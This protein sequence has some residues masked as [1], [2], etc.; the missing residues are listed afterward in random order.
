M[1]EEAMKTLG[2]LGVLDPFEHK[3]IQKN[4]FEKSMKERVK[5][6]DEPEAKST[7]GSPKS[8]RGPGAS[9]STH[10]SIPSL[11][12]GPAA[13]STARPL[14]TYVTGVKHFAMATVDDEMRTPRS[15]FS[16]YRLLDPYIPAR[17]YAQSISIDAIS[18]CSRPL[19]RLRREM[20]VIHLCTMHKITKRACHTSYVC[21][22]GSHE[23][24]ALDRSSS[25]G[26]D[27]T[28][29]RHELQ[30][31]AYKCR[32]HYVGYSGTK[33]AGL[34]VSQRTLPSR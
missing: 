33:L 2:A 9:T 16:V 6:V 13:S 26:A 20:I 15:K 14:N 34:R 18:C 8:P 25:E 11:S 31:A 32:R 5:N 30:R 21:V 23:L 19:A 29:E 4:A 27:G 7:P 1:R 22:A 17:R 28:A 10:S 24:R 12:L 3:N